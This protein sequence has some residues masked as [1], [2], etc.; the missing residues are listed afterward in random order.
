MSDNSEDKNNIIHTKI[1]CTESVTEYIDGSDWRINANANSGYSHAGLINNL[2]GKA[3]AN[4]WL[5]D[6][7]SSDEAAAHR[8]G[9]I[10]IHDLDCLTLV[11]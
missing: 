8:S 1:D 4:Y 11:S 2:A 7:Y 3:I 5:D 6:V 9:E 10:H